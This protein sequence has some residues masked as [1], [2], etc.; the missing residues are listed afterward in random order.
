MKKINP[1]VDTFHG[2]N[3]ALNPCSPQYRQGMAFDALNSRIDQSGIWNKAATLIDATLGSVALSYLPVSVNNLP[4]IK[5]LIINSL[6]KIVLNIKYNT[7]VCVGINKYAYFVA[8][9]MGSVRAVYWWDGT[10]KASAVG[11]VNNTTAFNY[12]LAGLARPTSNFSAREKIGTGGGRMVVGDYYYLY[13]WYDTAK[14]C[15][16][17]PSPVIAATKSWPDVPIVLT[18]FFE[19]QSSA[20]SAGAPRY[21]TNTKIR[22]YRSKVTSSTVFNP[23][24]TFYFVGEMAMPTI[25]FT[26]KTSDGGYTHSTHRL[27]GGAGSFN[28]I[29][30]G[31]FVYL[32]DSA[33]SGC[34]DGYYE[35][36]ATDSSTYLEFISTD[37]R[38]TAD[39]TSIKCE[40]FSPQ[41][42]FIDYMNDSELEDEYEGRG[43][44]PPVGV[45]YVV[46]FNNRMYYFVD[47]IMYWSS[48][49]RPDEVALKYT[50]NYVISSYYLNM[51]ASVEQVPK[52]STG[53]YAEAKYE[54]AELNGETIAAAYP[55]K[56]RLYLWTFEGSFGYLEGTYS[57]EGNRF[58]LLQRG[59]SVVSDKTFAESPY[60]LFGADREGIWTLQPSGQIYRLSKGVIDIDDSTKTTYAKQS[61]LNTSFGVWSSKLEEYLWCLV[62][63][64]ETVVCRQ[65]AY[66]PVRKVFNGIYAYTSLNGGCSMITSA[67]MQNYLTNGKTFDISSTQIDGSAVA[68]ASIAGN[69]SAIT[70]TFGTAHSF[71]VGDIIDVVGT[72]ATTW[73][74]LNVAITSITTYTIT[75]AGT[76]QGTTRAGTVTKQ[77]LAQTLKFWMGQDSLESVKDSLE[78]E[79]V[80]A[81]ITSA[82]TVTI[83]VY[84]NNIAS[85]TG[86]SSDTGIEH[87][88]A[89]LVGIV[90]VN[91]SGRMFLVEIS[92]PTDCVAPIVLLNYIANYIDWNEKALR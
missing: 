19:T 42:T 60:G 71:V 92:I 54:I 9:D 24:N 39:D 61:T 84:Q 79:I 66:N 14:Q 40:S 22:F 41:S 77:G 11:Y 72:G 83:I 28:G 27:T 33:G 1:R 4:H 78:I 44:P 69:G 36:Y 12:S 87:T 35:V 88:S 21:N 31:D 30:V 90:K 34:P 51:T 5:N 64:G 20:P 2:I 74:V 82:K 29:S 46:S 32:S 52:L 18:G 26:T 23:P 15:E 62:N 65:I 58:Y 8:D 16:S 3:N 17:L 57:T 68:F 63:T 49:G 45:D 75:Y 48:A 70:I 76:T 13:T 73:D 85:T 37:S 53:V 91:G 38:L 43:S 80:Y 81:S 47:N 67:G 55:Y 50:L 89:N 6:P 25:T 59:I 10:T 56:N 86:A 7:C